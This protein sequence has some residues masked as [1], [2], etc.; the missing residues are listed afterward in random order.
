MKSS[1]TALT[2][3]RAIRQAAW[4]AV[5]YA[6]FQALALP[7]PITITSSGWQFHIWT[8]LELSLTAGL[9]VGLFMGRLLALLIASIIGVYRLALLGRAT[10]MLYHVGATDEQTA[11]FLQNLVLMPFA[12][13]WIRGL[14]VRLSRGPGEQR[15]A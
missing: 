10:Y 4:A 1:P 11:L 13:L 6:V 3:V 5:G 2:Q 7:A 9:A 14:F 15:P 12:V 8:L